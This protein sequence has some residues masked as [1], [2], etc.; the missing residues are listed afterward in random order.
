MLAPLPSVQP[1]PAASDDAGEG[2][3][4]ARHPSAQSPV[5]RVPWALVVAAA[6]LPAV[7]ALVRLGRWHPDEIYQYLEPAF[8]RV[9]GYG[10][11]A[12]EWDVGLRNWAIP[13]VLAAFLRAAHA[14]GID[15]PI[16]CRAVLAVPQAAVLLL[17]MMSAWRY[18]ERRCRETPSSA[19]GAFL[20]FA[21]QAPVLLFAGRTMGESFSAAFLVV[22][23]ERLDRPGDGRRSGTWAGAML[24]LSVVA[25]YGSAVFVVVA[26]AWLVAKR[27][28]R[29]LGWTC[30]SG[31]AVAI[32]LGVLDW[33]T[34]GRPLH[35]L[36]AY[37]QF[38]VLSGKASTFFGAQ[39]VGFYLWALGAWF[40]LWIWP[41]LWIVTARER[42]LPLPAVAA[43]LYVLVLLA[44]PHKENRFLFPAVI[45]A[46]LAA[47]PGA[48]WLVA[49]CQTRRAR[50]GATVAALLAGSI[51]FTGP[52]R[53]TSGRDFRALARLGRDPATRG[54]LVVGGPWGSCGY[55]CVGRDVPLHHVEDTAE[56]TRV[57]EDSRVNRAVAVGPASVDLQRR[58]FAVV[59]RQ[60]KFDVLARR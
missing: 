25:R 47:A 17:A 37:L 36:I 43:V 7:F 3:P 31:G 4:L 44:T 32:S 57:L 22:A 41:G 55:F 48:A 27:R 50:V 59:E 11:R 19:K 21:L 54:I 60:G 40:A 6:A 42:R 46:A 30:A 9:H 28:W 58:G 15:H 35:S 5:R 29:A 24:G 2:A 53:P 8:F 39:P 26:L 1:A 18:V 23:F 13:F 45:L 51:A 16:A 49:R 34:W 20:L 38:N 56:I 10:V 14:A 12:W 33:A 52:D